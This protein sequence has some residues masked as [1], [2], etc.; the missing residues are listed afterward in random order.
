MVNQIARRIIAVIFAFG[1]VAPSQAAVLALDH[2]G[3]GLSF[4]GNATTAGWAFS[5]SS[6]ITVDALGF[7][8]TNSDGLEHNRIVGLWT[9]A[10]TPML[11]TQATI[12]NA[13][14]PVAST[15]ALGRWLFEDIPDLFLTPGDYVIGATVVDPNDLDDFFVREATAT[16]IGQISFEGNRVASGSN[17][18]LVFPSG[19]FGPTV[20]D[21]FFGPTFS[22]LQVPEPT[23]LA[24]LGIGVAGLAF[25]RRKRIAN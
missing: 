10:P 22:V 15:S 3:G 13:S 4:F 12:D 6:T 24:L 5:V 1:W 20:D 23:T 8:D 14:N 7:F 19:T 2:T 11:L 16:P 17:I 25:S 9:N 18:G 21:A